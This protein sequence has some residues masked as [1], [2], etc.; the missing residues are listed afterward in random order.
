MV[1]V[2]VYNIISS[3]IKSIH[4]TKLSIDQPSNSLT[5]LNILRPVVLPQYFE[6]DLQIT[7][8][9]NYC[10]TQLQQLVKYNCK[11]ISLKLV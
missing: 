6:Q 1:I 3:P 9:N 2:I 10:V 8:P 7:Q 5:S 11:Y 4:G